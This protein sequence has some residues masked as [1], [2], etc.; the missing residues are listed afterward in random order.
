MLSELTASYESCVA[1]MCGPVLY[2]T[3]VHL[4]LFSHDKIQPNKVARKSLWGRSLSGG[5][6]YSVRGDGRGSSTR[7]L[8]NVSAFCGTGGAIMGLFRGCVGGVMGV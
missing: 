6:S 5:G 8:F 7:P 2:T 3:A 4:K 1:G